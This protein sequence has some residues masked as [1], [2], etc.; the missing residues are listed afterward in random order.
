MVQVFIAG[1]TEL[2]ALIGA[3]S[4]LYLQRRPWLHR[5]RSSWR[6]L[7]WFAAAVSAGTR[8]CGAAWFSDTSR[9]AGVGVGIGA[10]LAL[11]PPPSNFEIA[12]MA[13]AIALKLMY[14]GE[15]T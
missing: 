10:R 2:A 8:G 9:K 14:L 4:S 1:L 12:E 7:R 6:R 11:C 13:R 15:P 3:P 5:P